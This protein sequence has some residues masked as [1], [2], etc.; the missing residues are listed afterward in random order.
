MVQKFL[1]T[2][3]NLEKYTQSKK[4]PV[5]NFFAI[6]IPVI[7]LFVAAQYAV[8]SMTAVRKYVEKLYQQE[9]VLLLSTA[10]EPDEETYNLYKDKTWLE[11]RFQLTK[12]D[13]ISLAVNLKDSVLQ[14]EL[15]GVVLKSSKMIDFQID[16]LFRHL[17]IG[18]YHHYFGERATG[19]SVLATIEKEPLIVKKAPR[20]SI[21]YAN[22]QHVVDTTKQ[23]VVHWMVSL[24]NDILLK[25]EGVDTAEN[26]AW[27]Q[28]KQFWWKQD[29]V[30]LKSDLRKTVLFKQPDY[31]PE[32]TLILNEADAKAIF[33]ALPDKPQVCIR[34]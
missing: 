32:M 17:N 29:L 9:D 10:N 28:S 20:D 1:F 21:E 6:L 34:L 22:Q 16:E 3:M 8:L 24:N 31:R 25:I 27:L 5:R 13:S 23:E 11:G 19:D 2:K 18:A 15:K 33:R 26:E 7:L 30:Q 12:E 14:L 4:H